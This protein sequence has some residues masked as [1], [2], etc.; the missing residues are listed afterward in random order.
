[1]IFER[2]SVMTKAELQNDQYFP[3]FILVRRPLNGEIIQMKQVEQLQDMFNEINMIFDKVKKIDDKVHKMESKIKTKVQNISDD[4]KNV[5]DKVD[6]V[7]KNASEFMSEI[8]KITEL[9]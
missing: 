2:E 5:D 6:K 4:V 7:V 9:I 8:K 1:M 3:Q